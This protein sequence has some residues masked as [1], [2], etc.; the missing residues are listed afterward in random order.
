MPALKFTYKNW[1]GE[2]KDREVAPIKIWFGHTDYHKEDQW[3]L[4]AI[5]IEKNA[6]RDF[7]VRDIIKFL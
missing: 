5:D 6:E 4:K 2:T 3:F 7:A 1:E